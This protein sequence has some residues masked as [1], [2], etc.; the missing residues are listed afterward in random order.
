M[1]TARKLQTLFIAAGAIGWGVAVLGVLLPWSVMTPLLQSMGSSYDFTDAQTQYWL[2]MAC[3]GWS[4]IGFLFLMALLKSRKYGN[5]VPLLA[6]CSIFEGIVLLI[7]G[8]LSGVALFPFAGDVL[9]C[10]VVGVGLL[11]TGA[12]S[13]HGDS[14]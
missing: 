1:K 6:V 5:M 9:F 11:W 2:R 13:S 12:V 14:Q 4:I 3:G 10:L 8:P 7:H